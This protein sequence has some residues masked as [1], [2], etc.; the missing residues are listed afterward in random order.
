MAWKQSPHNKSHSQ[1]TTANQRAVDESGLKGT[2][3]DAEYSP[4]LPSHTAGM[5]D[6]RITRNKGTEG[7]GGRG[8][9]S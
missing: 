9:Y 7:P 1:S 2:P 6:P 3:S 8:E 4:A 5:T